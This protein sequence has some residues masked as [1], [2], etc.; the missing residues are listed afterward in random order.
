MKYLSI[1]D[2]EYK[3]AAYK[4]GTDVIESIEDSEHT[5]NSTSR[6]DVNQVLVPPIG[7]EELTTPAQ[8]VIPSMLWLGTVLTSFVIWIVCIISL[9]LNIVRKNTGKAIFSGVAFIIPII[10]IILATMGR[11][12]ETY[13]ITIF[14]FLVQLLTLIIL[15]IFCFSKNKNVV[16]QTN[17]VQ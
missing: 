2:K 13:F 16:N 6:I 4:K 7:G 14:A 12:T 15:F 10:D 8:S 3:I 9:V 1:N 5:S 17:N 11:S